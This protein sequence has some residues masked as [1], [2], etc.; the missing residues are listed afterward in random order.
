MNTEDFILFTERDNKKISR[1]IKESFSD[2]QLNKSDFIRYC[3]NDL[4]DNE[5]SFFKPTL[6]RQVN[7]NF[8]NYLEINARS[9]HRA[10]TKKI[11]S[12]IEIGSIKMK[13][14]R[15]IIRKHLFLL[16]IIAITIKSP[17]DI[18]SYISL[19]IS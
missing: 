3:R 16:K 9:L 4:S 14:K 18:Y 6:H 7:S 2:E 17:E 12:E 8:P 13:L 10:L 19:F 1:I 5:L 11:I 15:I